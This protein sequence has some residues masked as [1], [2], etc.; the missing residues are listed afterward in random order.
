VPLL[1]DELPGIIIQH[2]FGTGGPY[3]EKEII[4]AGGNNKA[5]T[6]ESVPRQ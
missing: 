4:F 6:I 3:R 5:T 1:R 2:T